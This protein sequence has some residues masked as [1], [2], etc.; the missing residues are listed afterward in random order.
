MPSPRRSPATR[1]ERDSL[2][3]LQVP[4]DALYGAQTW[5]AVQNFPI[6]GLPMPRGFLRALG[7]IK[8]A[9]AEANAAL[10]H[11]P[12]DVAAAIG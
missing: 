2:G 12:A 8:A 1:T 10:G 9:A 7:L 4:A 6:S 5:R 3:E 11:L